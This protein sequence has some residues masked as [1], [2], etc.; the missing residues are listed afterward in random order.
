MPQHIEW[1]KLSVF[2]CSKSFFKTIIPPSVHQM[3]FISTKQH[4][5]PASFLKHLRSKL[6]TSFRLIAVNLAERL[7]GRSSQHYERHLFLCQ[8]L[9][10]PVIF[11]KTGKQY[12]VNLVIANHAFKRTNVIATFYGKKRI[13]A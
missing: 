2:K 8:K 6:T 11:N 10:S 1:F 4:H 5:T 12:S 13:V 3:A 7:I 9:C